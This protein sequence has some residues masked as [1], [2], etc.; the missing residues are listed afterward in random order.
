MKCRKTSLEKG[1]NDGTNS[2]IPE[3]LRFMLSSHGGLGMGF[4]PTIDGHC[5]DLP[6]IRDAVYLFRVVQPTGAI[7][8]LM[9]IL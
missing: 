9:P 6:S 4:E 7:G 8:E 3:L 5:I 1:F 2:N